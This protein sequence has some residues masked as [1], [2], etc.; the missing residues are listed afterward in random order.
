[1][2]Q[3][4]KRRFF[5]TLPLTLATVL[6]S[7][8][9]QMWLN[10]SV[11]FPYREWV[12]LALGTIIVAYGG[13]PFF[14]A[15]FSEIKTKSYGMMTLVALAITVGYSFSVAATF[16]FPG[17][18]LYWEIA[19]LISVFLFGHYL[20]MRAVRG[21]T[22]ALSKLAKLIPPTAHVIKNGKIIDAPTEQVQ[23]EDRVLVKPGEKIPVDGT[24]LRGESSVNEAMVTGESQPVIKRKGDTVIGGTINGDGSLTVKVMKTGQ[25]TVLAQITELIQQAQTT[26]PNVQYF[27]DRAAKLL[28]FIAV[29]VGVTTFLFW[30]FIIPKGAI[31]AATLAV[32]VIVIA[33]PHA[34]GLAIPV[35]T[36]IASEVAARAGVLIRDM[37]GLEILRRVTCVVLDKTG[38]LTEGKFGVTDVINNS[39]SRVQNSGLLS[40]AAAVE[41]HSQHP[42]AEGIVQF[43]KKKKI[44]IPPVEQFISYPGRGAEGIVR[45]RRILVGNASLMREK[46]VKD[47]GKTLTRYDTTTK[48]L[49]YIAIDKKIIGVIGVSDIIRKEAKDV[50]KILKNRGIKS[51]LLTGDRKAVGEDVGQQL[52]VDHVIA[53]V[54]PQDKVLEI[55]RLQKAG[56]IVAMVGDGV[57]DAPALTQANVGIAIGAGTDVAAASADIVLMQNNPQDI[58]RLLVLSETTNS[59]MMQNLWWAGGYNILAIPA[60]AG[61]FLP[62]GIALRPEWA[63]ILMSASSI[64]VVFNALQLRNVNLQE[65]KNHVS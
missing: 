29:F 65:S 45:K 39:E 10:I 4:F 63:A 13:L 59:K 32:S 54:L 28:T 49:V 35:V 51:I 5:I 9:I 40:L 20:E 21:A 8:H 58:L 26:K 42:I 44:A 11:D 27:A 46:K 23:V 24:V 33:C 53:E 30:L 18:S 6:A 22:S 14:K 3:D 34:L 7:P 55:K 47:P 41:S 1:M 52:G 2:E 61:V 38:T 60:A 15:A 25:E 31:L 50:V 56:E 12:L 37:R 43:A 57:N 62:F 17:E 64:I 36:I 19:T 16:L 48:A